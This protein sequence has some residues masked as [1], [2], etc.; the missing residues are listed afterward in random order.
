M[1][2]R[3]PDAPVLGQTAL[4]P[5]MLAYDDLEGPSGAWAWLMDLVE[6]RRWMDNGGRVHIA[7]E[8]YWFRAY[9]A[10][11]LPQMADAPKAPEPPC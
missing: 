1:A 7:V 8:S 6:V 10:A 3:A 9:P 4:L 5:S 2:K 11:P